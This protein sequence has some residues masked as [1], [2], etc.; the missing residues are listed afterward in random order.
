MI[1]IPAQPVLSSVEGA[2]IHFLLLFPRFRGGQ[3]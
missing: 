1:V 2:G 3:G